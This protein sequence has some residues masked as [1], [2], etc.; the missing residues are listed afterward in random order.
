VVPSVYDLQDLVFHLLLFVHES[1][2]SPGFNLVLVFLRRCGL[3]SVPASKIFVLLAWVWLTRPI[4]VKSSIQFVVPTRSLLSLQI[5]LVLN[6][7]R[8][9]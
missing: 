1:M 4:L 3:D 6:H 9:G 2:F 5:F 7:F 8:S